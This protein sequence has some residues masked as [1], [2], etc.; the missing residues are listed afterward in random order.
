[1][2]LKGFISKKITQKR[3]KSVRELLLNEISMSY[4]RDW[5]DEINKQN[6]IYKENQQYAK[7]MIHLLDYYKD[8]DIE[9][10]NVI[11]NII[12]EY[13]EKTFRI[14]PFAESFMSKQQVIRVILPENIKEKLNGLKLKLD[15][16]KEN[17]II[18]T[19]NKKDSA[20]ADEDVLGK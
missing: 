20:K 1:M 13:G 8:K 2:K 18:K 11:L 15:K 17:D 19:S 14:P 12:S 4:E 3:I 7:I 9:L 6:E 10:C 5:F 16:D